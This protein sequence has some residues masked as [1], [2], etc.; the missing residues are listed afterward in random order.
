MK[1]RLVALG[2]AAMFVA[3]AFAQIYAP[4]GRD[5]SKSLAPAVPS[6]QGVV[7][8][9]IE[10]AHLLTGETVYDLGC[11]DGRILIAAVQRYKVKAVGVE[12]SPTLANAARE[13]IRRLNLQEQASV[14]EGDMRE[15]DLTPADVVF[16][17]LVTE[18]NDQM[19]P[20]L[21]KYLRPGAR[22]VSHDFEV[23]G[24]KPVRT[25]DTGL[26]GRRPHVIYVYQMP[27]V[28]K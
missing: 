14:V 19:K 26:G 10:A 22:V 15:V 8:R 11:G 4:R 17:Y 23:R 6:P 5:L 13:N 7:D 3:P 27:P 28:K 16:L 24:W 21:E 1:S 18:A 9:M 25:E 20:R 12:L 2:I